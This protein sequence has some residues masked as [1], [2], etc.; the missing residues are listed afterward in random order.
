MKRVA[1]QGIRGS[2]HEE[3]THKFFGDEAIEIV[4]CRTFA[5][6]FNAMDQDHGLMGVVAIENTIA[7]ALLQNHEMLRESSLKVVGEEKIRIQHA[8]AILK[9]EKIDDIVEVNSH[10]IALMQCQRWLSKF[11]DIKIVEK[12][13]TASSAKEIAQQQ[14]HGHAAICSELAAELYGLK[15]L[16]RSIETNKR[17]FTRFLVLSHKS[18]SVVNTNFESVDKASLVFTLPHSAGALSKILTILS[19]Y[20]INMTKLHSMPLIGREWEYQFY[21]D[22]TFD[23]YKRYV[24]SIKAIRPLTNYIKILGEY[25]SCIN[26]E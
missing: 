20:D 7:G 2:Y 10:P 9:G 11:P 15:V 5:N 22:V 6:L 21:V 19:F 25:K 4:E 23:D 3:A 26:P 1:I 13:D 16:K 24:Q 8:V 12:S 14:L 17:N 18:K